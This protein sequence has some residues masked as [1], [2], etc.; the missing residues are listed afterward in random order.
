MDGRLDWLVGEPQLNDTSVTASR[1]QEKFVVGSDE[2]HF[3]HV[4]TAQLQLT[5][6]RL[7]NHR[8]TI[9]EDWSWRFGPWHT[10]HFVTKA[11]CK[12]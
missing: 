6:L 12:C 10:W 7:H 5:T 11:L 4:T 2:T 1:H 8:Q 9:L 3:H